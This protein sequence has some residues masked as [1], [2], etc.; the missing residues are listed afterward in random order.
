MGGGGILCNFCTLRYHPHPI[1]K[2]FYLILLNT[3]WAGAV[4]HV[5]FV[6]FVIAPIPYLK[7]V[8]GLFPQA[9]LS[10]GHIQ[11]FVR[12]YC[13]QDFSNCITG[14]AGVF[15]KDVIVVIDIL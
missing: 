3:R 12:C 8:G 5:A 1:S 14:A 15:R 4:S 2:S 7:F 10:K 11:N 13:A 6:H 9:Q